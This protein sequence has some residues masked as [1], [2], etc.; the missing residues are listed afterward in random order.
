VCGPARFA[1]ANPQAEPAFESTE[2]GGPSH[3][4]NQAVALCHDGVYTAIVDG[5]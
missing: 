5:D 3:R 2:I 1:V 4:G